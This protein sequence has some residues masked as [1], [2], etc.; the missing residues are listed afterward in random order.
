MKKLRIS[1]M[2]F[3]GVMA[4]GSLMGM[5]AIR[6]NIVPGASDRAQVDVLEAPNSQFTTEL[7]DSDGNIIFADNKEVSSL[8]FEKSYDFSKLPNGKYTFEVK[9]GDEVDYDNLL[10]NDGKVQI[11]SQEDQVS[12]DFKLDGKYLD[13][14]F[15]NTTKESSRLLLY[16]N[17][18]KKWIFQETLDPKFD[19]QQS[20]NLAGLHTGNYKAV[21]ISGDT[22]YDYDFYIG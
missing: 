15:P 11:L 7:K 6:V 3:L 22:S 18:S 20:L 21:L 2:L 5:G 13:F 10:I 4:S 9:Q 16:D 12:P 1:L 14:T 19:I 8:D 17:G